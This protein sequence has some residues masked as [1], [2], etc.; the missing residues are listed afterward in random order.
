[1]EPDRPNR[2]SDLYHRALGRAP[3]EPTLADR[4]TRGPLPIPDSLAMAR[5]IAEGYARSS[6]LSSGWTAAIVREP[7]SPSLRR[8]HD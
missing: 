2:V 5:Q 6:R 1:M 3:E 4:L 7:L 8:S